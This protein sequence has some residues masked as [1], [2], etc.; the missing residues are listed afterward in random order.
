MRV[1]CAHIHSRTFPYSHIT[2]GLHQASG[3]HTYAI[4]P[5]ACAALMRRAHR[6]ARQARRYR[7]RRAGVP[8]QPGPRNTPHPRATQAAP[9]HRARDPLTGPN[10]AA[11]ACGPAAT[12][13]PSSSRGSGTRRSPRRRCCH[14]S[15]ASVPC[16][17]SPAAR[18]CRARSLPTAPT[19]TSPATSAAAHPAAG[20][21]IVVSPPRGRGGWWPPP[22]RAADSV[23]GGERVLSATQQSQRDEG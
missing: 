21:P 11:R 23:M 14:P 3:R 13:L 18:G 15:A 9:T 2:G 1:A 8:S 20:R 17:Q 4:L 19:S 22:L 5:H 7:A 6:P 10:N 12:N 16:M